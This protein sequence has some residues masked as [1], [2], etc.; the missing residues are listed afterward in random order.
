MFWKDNLG[1]KIN[2]IRDNHIFI[3]QLSI[4]IKKERN[5]IKII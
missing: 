3:T 5:T 1:L 4:L 2:K